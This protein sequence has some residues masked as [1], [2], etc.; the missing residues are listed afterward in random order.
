MTHDHDRDA[1][2]RTRA[3]LFGVLLTLA[4]CL[5][6]GRLRGDWLLLPAGYWTLILALR[7]VMPGV[8]RRR[9]SPAR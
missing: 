2:I 8:A 4:A 1:A 5:L 9:G 7:V 6:S 3:D